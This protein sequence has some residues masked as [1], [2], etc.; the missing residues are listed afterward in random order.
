MWSEEC[1]QGQAAHSW[2]PMTVP[3]RWSWCRSH[4]NH[5]ILT[6]STIATF[7]TCN[8]PE[9]SHSP[10]RPV[11]P[12]MQI[13]PEL[14]WAALRWEWMEFRGCEPSLGDVRLVWWGPPA[15]QALSPAVKCAP[16]QILTPLTAPGCLLKHWTDHSLFYSQI[17]CL[18]EVWCMAVRFDPDLHFP[19][20][21]PSISPL[22]IATGFLPLD[23]SLSAVE[24][25]V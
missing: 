20:W 13:R 21:Q 17:P 22:S 8:Y 15:S 11:K 9:S 24:L 10:A 25:D 16:I 5:H 23:K 3:W 18:G 19:L 12:L 6:I 2:H 1:D 7:P 4:H 14:R